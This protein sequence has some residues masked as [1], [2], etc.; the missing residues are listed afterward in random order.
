MA[1]AVAEVVVASGVA[2]V[3][4]VVVAADFGLCQALLFFHFQ[5]GLVG[6]ASSPRP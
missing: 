4:A 1:V 2:V 3:D 5:N 6:F